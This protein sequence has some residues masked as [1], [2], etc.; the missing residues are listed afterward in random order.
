MH[1]TANTTYSG[2][3]A[4]HLFHGHAFQKFF[5]SPKFNCLEEGIIHITVIIQE[6]GYFPM[7]F[8]TGNRIYF[9]FSHACFS[10]CSAIL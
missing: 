9:Y 3:G 6:N 5:I 10:L 7:T 8:Q 4:W 2:N 1:T